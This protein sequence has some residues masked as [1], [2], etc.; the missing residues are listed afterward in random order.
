MKSTQNSFNNS[1]SP[2]TNNDNLRNSKRWTS[3][4]PLTSREKSSRIWTSLPKKSSSTT[5]SDTKRMLLNMMAANGQKEERSI[6][7][8]PKT[9]RNIMSTAISSSVT[10]TKMPTACGLQPE[11]ERI[12]FRTYKPSFQEGEQVKKRSVKLWRRLDDSPSM[13]LPA[14]R[15]LTMKRRQ[16]QPKRSDSREIL[17]IG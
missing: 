3:L 7:S 9:T 6:K 15:Q 2:L 8:S 13:P 14:A 4:R 16:S 10:N 5:S 1:S 12:S 11:E 17:S